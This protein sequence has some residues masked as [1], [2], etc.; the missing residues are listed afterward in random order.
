MSELTQAELKEVLRYEPDTGHFYWVK[1]V[2]S[3][4]S[5]IKPAGTIFNDKTGKTCKDGTELEPHYVCHIQLY[6]KLY[7][8]HRLAFL[9]MN[10]VLPKLCIDHINGCCTDNRWTNLREVSNSI[11]MQNRATP[12]RTNLSGFIGV[13]FRKS[14]GKYVA[15]IGVDGKSKHIGC[16]ESAKQAADARFNAAYLLH[17]G[18][19]NERFND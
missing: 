9:Y 11:N 8:S 5:F 17:E 14:L 19:V 10:G 13:R 6:K 4:C 15:A 3:R 1:R 12:K 18:F 16:Y 2:T 7:K